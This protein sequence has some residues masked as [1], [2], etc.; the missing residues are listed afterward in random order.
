MIPFRDD[1]PHSSFPIITIIFIAACALVFFLEISLGQHQSEI[2]IASFGMIPELVSNPHLI[3]DLPI[4]P[5]MT[6]LT[7]MFLHGGWMHLIGNM[8]YLWIFMIYLVLGSNILTYSL[9]LWALKRVDSSHAALFVYFQPLVATTLSYFMLGNIPSIR[10]Y[11][12]SLLIVGGIFV[13]SYKKWST[14]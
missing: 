9:N 10:F 11:I 14:S 13:A 8:L 1:N 4:H 12:S 3:L 5:Y 7:S 6:F 2:F